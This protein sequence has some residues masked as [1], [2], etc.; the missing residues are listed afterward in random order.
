MRVSRIGT[1]TAWVL[2]AC[3]LVALVLP[4]VSQAATAQKI[5]AAADNTVA[6]FKTEFG[7]G[8]TVLRQA[9]AVLVFPEVI[10]AG[11]G[12]GG[13]YGEGVLRIQGRSVGYY[14][15]TSGS[16][17]LQLG[18]QRKSIIIAFL[19]DNA[20][21][22]FQEEASQDKAFNISG[23]TSVVLLTKGTEAA[24]TSAMNQPIV[25]FV[26]NQAGLMGSL[27]LQGSKIARIQRQ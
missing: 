6:Q 16:I 26:F 14:S 19:Q 3:A 27:S 15:F 11:V 5:D 8:P 7:G 22:R 23:D 24:V 12:I 20:L 18:A 25:G 10:Q 17:G 4:A 13:Q 21:R 1:M 2:W 9:K